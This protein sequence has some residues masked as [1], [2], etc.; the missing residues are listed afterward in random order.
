MESIVQAK[1]LNTLNK[2]TQAVDLLVADKKGLESRSGS[3]DPIPY[4]GEEDNY[5]RERYQ[6][7]KAAYM[8]LLVLRA[9]NRQV[10]PHPPPMD[11]DQPQFMKVLARPRMRMMPRDQG[12]SYYK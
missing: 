6:N 4:P 1:I 10:S 7:A 3:L 9:K 8:R 11:E 2:L 5:W 12:F